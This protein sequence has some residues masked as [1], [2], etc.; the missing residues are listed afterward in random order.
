M[1]STYDIADIVRVTG[2]FSTASGST[3]YKDPTTVNLHIETPD[4][5]VTSYAVSPPTT[6]AD[7]VRDTTGEFYSDITTTG[8]GRYEYRYTSTGTLTA[9]QESGFL[10]RVRAVTT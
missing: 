4:G 8:S 1:P 9:S 2:K 7:I 5:S 10:V 3:A 6:S